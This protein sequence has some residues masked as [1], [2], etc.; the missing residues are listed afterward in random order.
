M[1]LALLG[2]LSSLAFRTADGLTLSPASVAVFL[3]LS[4]QFAMLLGP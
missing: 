4:A 3:W 1:Q 2:I